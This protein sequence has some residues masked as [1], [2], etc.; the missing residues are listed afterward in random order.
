M[1]ATTSGVVPDHVLITKDMKSIVH[2]T[3]NTIKI[4]EEHKEQDYMTDA[5]EEPEPQ[6]FKEEQVELIIFKDERQLIVN[7]QT[8]AF[9]VTSSN[10]EIFNNGPELQQMMEIKVE[11]EP[12]QI[13]EEQREPD[14]AQI[15]EEQEELCSN[16]G[17]EQLVVKQETDS[18]K[19][20][21]TY[22]QKD[23]SELEPNQNQLLSENCPQEENQRQQE[24][25]Q[26]HSESSEDKDL[27]PEKD[28][29][30]HRLNY[31]RCQHYVTGGE[32]CDSACAT[33]ID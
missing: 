8:N 16:Q 31:L 20:T 22:E 17:E 28:T 2:K 5:K 19:V 3:S 1:S 18:F 10:E 24:G 7:Q 32:E 30:N 15:K 26:K 33:R 21:P 12:V 27:E 23:D 4:T 14:P 9:M 25:I 13:K 29:R 11:P 6:P